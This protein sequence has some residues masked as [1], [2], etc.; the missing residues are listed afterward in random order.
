[1][2]LL[3]IWLLQVKNWVSSWMVVSLVAMFSCMPN[4]FSRGYCCAEMRV[5]LVLTCCF[6]DIF[7]PQWSSVWG[8]ELLFTV[9]TLSVDYYYFFSSVL[10][11]WVEEVM[12]PLVPHWVDIQTHAKML[13]DTWQLH[14]WDHYWRKATSGSLRCGSR[15]V[16]V[17]SLVDWLVCVIKMCFLLIFLGLLSFQ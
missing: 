3:F 13:K 6:H 11:T 8:L 16:S 10:P 14:S 1:M 4:L 12:Y 7:F 5:H 2:L 9:Q 17:F 15:G